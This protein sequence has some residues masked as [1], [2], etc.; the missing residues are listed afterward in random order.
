MTLE[1]ERELL[2]KI[3]RTEIIKG[4]LIRTKFKLKLQCNKGHFIEKTSV[5][6]LYSQNIING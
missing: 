1:R 5:P 4:S 6:F 3:Q 2:N